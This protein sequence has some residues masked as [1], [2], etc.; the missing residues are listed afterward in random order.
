MS[1]S[2][3]NLHL[4]HGQVL[5]ALSRGAPPTRTL[6]DQ[7]RHLRRLGVP[8]RKSELGG[9]RGNRVYYR[10][11]HLV[12]LGVALFGLQRG[13]DPREVVVMVTRDR[14]FLRA[15]YRRAW[16]QQ[17]A[18]GIDAPWVKSRGAQIPFLGNELFLRMHDRYAEAPGKIEMVTPDELHDL[19]DLLALTEKYPG[20]QTRMLLPLT[21]LVLELVA[22]AKEAPEL[23]PGP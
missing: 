9:G 16:M 23:K 22:W 3:P 21:R 10:F 15:M 1:E 12:E 4:T 7:V 6:L 5:W 2:I 11:E 13:M 20:E 8:F 14:K 17:P 18:T 19:R